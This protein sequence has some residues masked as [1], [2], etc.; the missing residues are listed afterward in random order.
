MN[1]DSSDQVAAVAAFRRQ[2]SGHHDNADQSVKKCSGQHPTSPGNPL[3]IPHDINKF[4]MSS[5]LNLNQASSIK[6][7]DLVHHQGKICILVILVEVDTSNWK[8]KFA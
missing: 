3:G 1:S 2:Y 4:Y 8:G 6:D 7:V 5:L